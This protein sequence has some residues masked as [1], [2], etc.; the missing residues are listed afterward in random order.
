MTI[1][2]LK[3]LEIRVRKAKELYYNIMN[4]ENVIQEI[5][6]GMSIKISTGESYAQSIT[7][8][9]VDQKIAL[10]E[11]LNKEL[12]ANKREFEQL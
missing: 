5:Q 10:I 6:G 12:E 8:D 9:S 3:G 7:I 4:L 1:E 11:I 2:N